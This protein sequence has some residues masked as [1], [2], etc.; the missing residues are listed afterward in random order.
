MFYGKI[1]FSGSLPA[2]VFLFWPPSQLVKLFISTV[3]CVLLSVFILS[4]SVSVGV[5][6]D[7]PAGLNDVLLLFEIYLQNSLD[8]HKCDATLWGREEDRVVS[9]VQHLNTKK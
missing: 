5:V 3:L 9:A 6:E 4:V 7:V 8:Q 2:P 1:I